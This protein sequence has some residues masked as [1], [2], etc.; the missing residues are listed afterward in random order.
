MINPGVSGSYIYYMWSSVYTNYFTIT[1]A[2]RYTA[3][4]NKNTATMGGT[5]Y[6]Y[7]NKTFQ[8]NYNLWLFCSNNAGSMLCAQPMKL[9]SCKIYDNGTLI[10]DYVP[11]I[12]SAGEYGLFDKVNYQFYTN[13]GTGS[14]TGG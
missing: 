2:N 7:T 12:N 3:E 11:V 10:R 14:F 6:T 1:Y 5:S 9:Y 8:L 13:A 4:I